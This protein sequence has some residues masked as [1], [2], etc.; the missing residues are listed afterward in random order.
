MKAAHFKAIGWL[1]I[2]A[3][4]V[5]VVLRESI[6]FPGLERL[7]GIE[8]IVGRENVVRLDDGG[9]AFTNPGAMIRWT[10]A[11]GAIGLM[12]GASGV[13]L[14]FRGRRHRDV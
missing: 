3:G 9:Y 11:V 1:A 4:V 10:L 2:L 8:T 6:V 5:V 14:L 7:L 13:V 12:I